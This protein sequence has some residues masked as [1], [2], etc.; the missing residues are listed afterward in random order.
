[1]PWNDIGGGYHW[2]IRTGLGSGTGAATGGAATAEPADGAGPDGAASRA[3]GAASG[4]GRARGAGRAA[5][6]G[7]LARRADRQ[8]AAA[9][10]RPAAIDRR[11]AGR[12]PAAAAVD[13]G[14]SIAAA[15]DC[16]RQHQ[17][18]QIGEPCRTEPMTVTERGRIQPD[19]IY[20]GYGGYDQKPGPAARIRRL[21]RFL[22]QGNRSEL[23]PAGS[24]AGAPRRS[25]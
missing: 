6:A 4:A 19:T 8:Q 5:R 25:R 11:P 7:D 9:R 23:D 13:L 1:M 22:E 2:G 15:G 24:P 18:N 17:H 10:R 16:A 20:D 12:N 3:G 14:K 21:R